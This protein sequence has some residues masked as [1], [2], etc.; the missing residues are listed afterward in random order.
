MESQMEDRSGSIMRAKKHGPLQLLKDLERIDGVPVRRGAHGGKGTTGGR[1][2]IRVKHL[3]GFIG[4][5]LACGSGPSQAQLPEDL[6]IVYWEMLNEGIYVYRQDVDR[7]NWRE[8]REQRE[9]M[10]TAHEEPKLLLPV[11]SSFKSPFGEQRHPAEDL[12]DEGIVMVRDPEGRVKRLTR[13]DM[14]EGTV[15]IPEDLAL[16][17]RYLL[18]G[19]FDT[20]E[21]DVNGDGRLETVRVYAKHLVIHYKNDGRSGDDP[22]AFFNDVENMALE[23]GPVVSSAKSRVSGASQRPHNFYDMEVLYRN[24][25][26]RGGLVTVTAEV[27][28]WQRTFQTDEAGRFRI[29]PFDDRSEDR[30]WS[31]YLYTATHYD[32]DQGVFHVATLPVIVYRNRPEW[33][34]LTA[35]FTVWTIVGVGGGLL[36]IFAYARRKRNLRKLALVSFE[37]YRI[38]EG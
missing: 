29:M 5:V 16:N 1:L 2:S 15:V 17:G 37:H 22:S 19:R 24:R 36:L 7:F 9:L 23:I 28:G 4:L 33:A 31:K 10:R 38:K 35:G 8:I 13:A 30:H 26:L 12:V 3:V 21:R 25:P 18:G 32:H 11:R 20:G 6:P 34:S 14:K 27:S